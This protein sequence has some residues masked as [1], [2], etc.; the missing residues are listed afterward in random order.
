V[1]VCVCGVCA[2]VGLSVHLSN[3]QLDKTL[4]KVKWQTADV[5]AFVYLSFLKCPVCR[6]SFFGGGD[7]CCLVGVWT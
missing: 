3:A 6:C 7:T 4:G 2:G 5:L 1:C